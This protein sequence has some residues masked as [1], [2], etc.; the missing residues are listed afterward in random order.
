MTISPPVYVSKDALNPFLSI[1]AQKTVSKPLKHGIFLRK[2]LLHWSG[3]GH[4]IAGA[5]AAY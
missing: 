1:L 3:F 4:Q 5:L 2:C